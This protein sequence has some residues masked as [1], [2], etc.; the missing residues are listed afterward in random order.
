MFEKLK[1]KIRSGFNRLVGS[2]L[3][4]DIRGIADLAAVA[5]GL[6]T[7]AIATGIVAYVLGSIQ[8]LL[9][10]SNVTAVLD[11]GIQAMTTLAQRPQ[12]AA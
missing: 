6:G 1:L 10:N 11:Y 7:A 4:S 2:R 8:T 12:V 3:V 5:I 9:D